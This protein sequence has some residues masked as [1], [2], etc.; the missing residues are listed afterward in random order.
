MACAVC[1]AGAA[2]NGALAV[3]DRGEIVKV[4]QQ[5]LTEA[6][7][8]TPVTGSFNGITEASV[9]AFQRAAGLAEDG[10]AGPRT[11]CAL[12]RSALYKGEEPPIASRGTA[13]P[14]LDWETINAVWPPKGAAW[15]TDVE[16]RTTMKVIRLGGS[17]HADV[18]PASYADTAILKSWYGGSWSW[19]RRAVIFRYERIR[20]GASINGMPHGQDTIENGFPG[21]FCL[22]FLGSRIHATGK[23]DADHQRMVMR[24]ARALLD[25]AWIAPGG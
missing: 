15:L 9:R 16:H 17:L 22:H 12:G 4:L 24:A 13:A 23:L 14:L 11:W 21:Q 6:G 5:W 8:A 20:C 3:G 18:E 7:F 2:Q 25:P 19:S 1:L 10:V